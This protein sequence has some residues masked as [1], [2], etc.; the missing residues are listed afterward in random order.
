LSPNIKGGFMGIWIVI[1][2]VGAMWLIFTA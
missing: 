1:G 2:L